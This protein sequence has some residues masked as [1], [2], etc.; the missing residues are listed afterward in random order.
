MIW[1]LTLITLSPSSFKI[2]LSK[3]DRSSLFINTTNCADIVRENYRKISWVQVR[4]PRRARGGGPNTHKK[5]PRSK[6]YEFVDISIAGIIV[7]SRKYA[8]I[9]KKQKIQEV[10]F[11]PP[12]NRGAIGTYAVIGS[13]LINIISFIFYITV[14]VYILHIYEQLTLNMNAI[15]L[16]VSTCRYILRANTSDPESWSDLYRYLPYLRQALGCCVCLGILHKPM[17]PAE[18][19]STILT[20]Y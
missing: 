14:Y 1:K 4:L 8:N 3:S 2:I 9:Y 5:V 6:N 20:I 18:K 7:S 16:Y 19:V 10:V 11:P 15:G 17:G 13:I 12:F